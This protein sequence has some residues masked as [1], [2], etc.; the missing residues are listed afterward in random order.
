MPSFLSRHCKYTCTYTYTDVLL[1]IARLVLVS[2]AC[3]FLELTTWLGGTK[4]SASPWGGPFL[5]LAPLVCRSSCRVEAFLCPLCRVYW[6]RSCSALFTQSC[7]SNHTDVAF[8]ISEGRL[9]NSFELF[10]S[11]MDKI[12]G[13]TLK[14]YYLLKDKAGLSIIIAAT[15]AIIVVV[16]AI[17]LVWTLNTE[18]FACMANIFMKGHIPISETDL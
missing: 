15:A 14:K 5:P 4:W 17:F 10:I 18:S 8:G 3:M 2:L 11:E 7:R 6:C 13:N 12:V 16:I 9:G 1:I